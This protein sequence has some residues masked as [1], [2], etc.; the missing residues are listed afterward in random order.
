MKEL[1]FTSEIAVR[2][3][4]QMGGDHM[5]V[6]AAKVSTSGEE[7]SEFAKAEATEGNFGLINYLIKHRHGTPFE[8]GALTFFV[9]APIF[10]WREWHRHRIGFCLAGDTEIWSESI[11]VNHGR[12]LHKHRLV[13]L[14]NRWK[15]GVE[16]SLGR[17]RKLPSVYNQKLRVLNEDTHLF[18]LGGINDVYESGVK[19][20]YLLQTADARWNS[21]RCSAEH[22]IL[23]QDGWAKICDLSGDEFIYVSGKRNSNMVVVP[24]SLRRGIGVWTSMMRNKLIRPVDYCYICSRQFDRDD[25]VLDHEISV[26]E[27]LTK[28]L[29]VKNIK[30]A[31]KICHREKTNREQ[32]LS[33]RNIVAGSKLSRLLGKPKRVS[34]EMTYDIEMNGPWHNF[35]ANGIVVHNSYNEESGRYKQ[36]EPV[37]WIPPVERKLVPTPE[38]K[39]A[40]PTF[41]QADEATYNWLVE[42]L[43]AGYSDA[44]QRYEARLNRGIAKEVARAGLPVGIFSSCWV[45]CNPRSLMSFLSLR[46]HEPNAKFVSYP[47]A[48]IEVAA[49]VAEQ[50]LATGWPLAYKAF[51][52]NGR[53][54]S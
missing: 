50:F 48:E 39:A 45:T 11:G 14:C 22:R 43:K 52:E 13:D 26:A 7:A 27:D 54:G 42:D 18:E 34:E 35:V 53:V 24:P 30:P 38:Y 8:H 49:R 37:F 21:L 1:K 9:H 41:Q 17:I 5:I 36:L 10:V 25:L 15:N 29:N 16:D 19:E 4:Q 20:L 12:T 28:A 44:Y 33:D 23:T 46:V 32:K 2:I 47:Q 51:C 31:C 40:R 6:A 3:I